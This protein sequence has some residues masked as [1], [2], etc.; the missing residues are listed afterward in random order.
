MIHNSEFQSNLRR[1]ISVWLTSCL[2]FGIQLLCLC[3][4][5]NRFPCLVKSKPV[6]QEVSYTM[7]LLTMVIV[8]WS[9]SLFPNFCERKLFL[10]LGFEL[11]SSAKTIILIIPMTRPFGNVAIS[12]QTLLAEK[13]PSQK[14]VLSEIERTT[15]TPLTGR[16]QQAESR[17]TA[18][19]G[20]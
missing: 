12:S 17:K 4:T 15:S 19:L 8:L 13:L 18:F 3:S 5:Y 1:R 14:N 9:I 11:D 6:K 2:I 20:T 10:S 7:I 16:T